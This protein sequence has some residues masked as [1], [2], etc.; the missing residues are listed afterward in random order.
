MATLLMAVTGASVLAHRAAAG[1]VVGIGRLMLELVDVSV[2][3]GETRRRR[4]LARPWTTTETVALL[5]PSGSGKSTLLRAIAGLE[6]PAAG[7]IALDGRD[8]ADVPVHERG[9]GLMF[10]DYALFPHRDVG[11]NVA[12]GLRMAATRASPIA[13]RVAEMLELVGLAGS[14]RA[15]VGAALGRRAAAG[16]PGPRAGAAPRLL[17]LDEPMGSLD[18]ALRERLPDELAASSSGWG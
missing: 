14:E 13:A 7:R 15:A 17:M 1:R 2:A 4:R 3:Y 8:L 5:G 10:Q 18:R 12:F 9:F 6:P 16:G 11:G